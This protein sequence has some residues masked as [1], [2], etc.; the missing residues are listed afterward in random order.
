MT[1]IVHFDVEKIVAEVEKHLAEN[2]ASDMKDLST[3]AMRNGDSVQIALLK[4]G[5]EQRN[6]NIP[7][8]VLA[9]AAAQIFATFFMNLFTDESQDP[10][11]IAKSADHFC[12]MIFHATM[13]LSEMRA[14]GTTISTPINPIV[15][16]RA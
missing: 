15:G 8:P 13:G 7:A 2:P 16:G 1:E 6:L 5:Y 11:N 12:D 10:D 4:W 3:I 9:S 14:S